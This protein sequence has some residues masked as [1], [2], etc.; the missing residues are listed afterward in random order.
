M[1]LQCWRFSHGLKTYSEQ[2]KANP[3][4]TFKRNVPQIENKKYTSISL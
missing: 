3:N 2:G 4:K 1:C